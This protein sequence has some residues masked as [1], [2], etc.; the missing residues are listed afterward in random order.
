MGGRSSFGGWKI[1][2][3]D[4]QVFGG[5]FCLKAGEGDHISQGISGNAEFDQVSRMG[6]SALK[7][8]CKILA[9]TGFYEKY[10]DEPCWGEDSKEPD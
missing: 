1:T 3:K 9:K 2:K 10:R 7:L 6:Y 8:T 4:Y 5:P